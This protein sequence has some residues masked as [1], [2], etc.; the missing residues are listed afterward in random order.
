ML[1][2]KKLNNV[3]IKKMYYA[4]S[5]FLIINLWHLYI[6]YF[7]VIIILAYGFIISSIVLIFRFILQ[8]VIIRIYPNPY[9][10]NHLLTY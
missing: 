10:L 7:D 8:I 1:P 3:L 2:K 5:K 9:R 4:L 6:I